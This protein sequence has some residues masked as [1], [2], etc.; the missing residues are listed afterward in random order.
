MNSAEFFATARERYH[1]KIRKER[2]D[3]WPWSNDPV[4][5]TWFFCNVRREDD[6][7]TIW[8][9]K[10]IREPLNGN[11]EKTVRGS[12]I[13][14]WFNKIETVE[15]IKDLILG[16]WD[17]E[18]AYTRLQDIHPIVTGAYIILG[19]QGLP[20]LEGVLDCIGNSLSKI[21]GI[22][23][24]IT[25][26]EPCT[27]KGAWEA[28]RQINYLGPF[29][30]YEVVTDLRWTQ[31]LDQAVDIFTWANAGPGCTHGLGRVVTGNS[32][33]YNRGSKD[34]QVEMVDQMQRLLDLSTNPDFWPADWPQWEMREVEHWLCEYDKY[35]RGRE[36][37]RLKRRYRLR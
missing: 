33:Q 25:S 31:L 16:T 19:T 1:I 37:E 21:P 32:R 18:E 10:N 36:G 7:N 11:H 5:Q 12:L 9:R 35:C 30:A 6:K 22:V 24:E 2:G 4:F 14:R 34:G 27:L 28:L 13:F 20:K 29:M 17:F 8:Y 15:L 26:A 3:P 23:S